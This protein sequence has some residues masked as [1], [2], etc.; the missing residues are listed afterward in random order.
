MSVQDWIEAAFTCTMECRYLLHVPESVDENTILAIV[1]HGYG[2]NPAE[3]LRLSRMVL[4][5]DLLIASIGGPNQHYLQD[6]PGGTSIGYNWGVR[7]HWHEAI[8][9]HTEMV[10]TVRAQMNQKFGVTSARTLLAG[11]SQPVGL[12][13]RYT[14][15]YPGKI[16]GLLAICGGVPKDWEEDKYLPVS[17]PILHIARDQDEFFPVPVTATFK[18]R[19]EIHAADVTFCLMEGPHR[20]PS[21]AAPIIEPWLRRVFA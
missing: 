4:G 18:A 19:L 2:Q 15:T 8:R 16:G 10:D 9:L 7:D 14:G 12:N 1:L 20:F 13:Y 6:K 21:K 17:T 11:Y 3:M 5:K